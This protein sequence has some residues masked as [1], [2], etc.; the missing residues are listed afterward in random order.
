MENGGVQWC[1]VL[2][3]NQRSYVIHV[4][5]IRKSVGGCLFLRKQEDSTHSLRPEVSVDAVEQPCEKKT[6]EE[7]T[8][9]TLGGRYRVTRMDVHSSFFVSD[10]RFDDSVSMFE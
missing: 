2:T 7:C 3:Q 10:Y 9:V 6:G 1:Q 8:P 5:L 4:F